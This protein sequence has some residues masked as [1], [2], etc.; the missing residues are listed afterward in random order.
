MSLQKAKTYLLALECEVCR[1]L[2]PLVALLMYLIVFMLS[3]YGMYLIHTWYN[4]E[5][6]VIEFAQG[7][8][9]DSRLRADDRAVIYQPVHKMRDCE[10]RVT[11]YFTGDCGHIVFSESQ[12]AIPKGFAGQKIFS[13]QVP[14][15]AIVGACEF[16]F[17][18]KYI[19]NPFDIMMDRHVYVSPPINFTVI[20]YSDEK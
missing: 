10:G 4:D 12:T 16:R 1:E 7:S 20:G 15:E 2:R 17:R 9:S 14:H 18:A 19:C 11:R 3:G 13:I 5:E 8:I 6:P